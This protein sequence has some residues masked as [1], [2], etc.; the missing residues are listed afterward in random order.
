MTRTITHTI[1]LRRVASVRM[2]PCVTLMVPSVVMLCVVTAPSAIL[3]HVPLRLKLHVRHVVKA[4]H[5]VRQPLQLTAMVTLAVHAQVV[6]LVAA[7]PVAVAAALVVAA[8][9]VVVEAAEAVAS[10]DTNNDNGNE[11]E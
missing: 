8:P 4:I 3:A 10:E 2:A 5:H 6:A 11:N 1:L 9:V 7:V